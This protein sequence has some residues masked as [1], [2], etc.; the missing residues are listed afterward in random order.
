[1]T[2]NQPRDP[3]SEVVNTERRWVPEWYTWLKEL[4]DGINAN[5]VAVNANTAAIN[6]HTS[7][8]QLIN[9]NFS[10]APWIN[11]TPIVISDTGTITTSLF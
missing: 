8:L 4:V 2:V 3:Y 10:V 1:M 11:W 5:T 7:A 9:N 6:A